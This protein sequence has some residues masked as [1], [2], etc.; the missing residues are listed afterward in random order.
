MLEKIKLIKKITYK[1]RYITEFLFTLIFIFFLAQT[2]YLKAYAGYFHKLYLIGTLI[3]FI[4]LVIN[5]I[6]NFKK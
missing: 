6:Y 2:L 4:I 5:I 1:M 3:W